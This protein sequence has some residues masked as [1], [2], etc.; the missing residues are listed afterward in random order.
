MEF[1]WDLVKSNSCQVSRNFDFAYVTAVFIDPALLIEHDQRWDYGEER[2]RAL[3]LI[4]G[5]VLW[6]SSQ[7]DL[8]PLGLF[9]LGE[10]I[11]GRS[12]CMKK[13]IRVSVDLNNPSS[14]PKGYVNKKLLDATSERLI[15]LHERQDDLEAMQDAAK[16]AKGVR[17]RIG[18][19]Q[20]EFSNRIEVS[21][22][23]IRNW[24]QGKRSPT[25]AAKALLKILDRAPEIALLALST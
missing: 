24:E 25:G 17:E 16:Y 13:I 3:G 4:D 11:V 7:I 10:L 9:R 19:S 15:K 18:L 2:F 22:E 23:T 5:K 20:L 21:L 6:W 8:E 1:E 12:N 14:F